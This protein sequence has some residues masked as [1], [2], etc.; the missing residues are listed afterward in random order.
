MSLRRST[1]ER[2][3]EMLHDHFVF[4]QE[5]KIDIRVIEDDLINFH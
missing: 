1:K 3:S 2:K 5:H 4:L